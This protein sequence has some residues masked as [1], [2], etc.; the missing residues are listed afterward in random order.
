MLSLFVILNSGRAM[1]AVFYFPKERT[2][3]SAEFSLA[4]KGK[5][6]QELLLTLL[7]WIYV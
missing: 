1:N 4:C 7:E 2:E 3:S 6:V 5:P